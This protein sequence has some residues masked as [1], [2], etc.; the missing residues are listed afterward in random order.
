MTTFNFG[1]TY[2]DGMR[3]CAVAKTGHRWTHLVF[4]DGSRIRTVRVRSAPTFTP[5]DGYTLRRLAKAML[6]P[7]N[8]L[9]LPMTITKGAR[10]ILKEALS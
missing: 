4:M 3:R 6:K 9:G 7:R 10:K 5:L 2:V 8:C 1:K